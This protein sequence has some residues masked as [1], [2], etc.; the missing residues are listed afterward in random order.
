MNVKPTVSVLKVR[1]C[2][3]R[4]YGHLIWEN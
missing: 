1:L 4:C 3:L 2:T